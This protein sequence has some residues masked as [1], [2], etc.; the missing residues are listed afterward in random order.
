MFLLIRGNGGQDGAHGNYTIILPDG[1]GT[2][3]LPPPPPSP[4]ELENFADMNILAP[5]SPFRSDA[6][7][8]G[9]DV[10]QM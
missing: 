7:A 9:E 10:R 3:T 4:S 5:P 1:S 2:I 6:T 8:G